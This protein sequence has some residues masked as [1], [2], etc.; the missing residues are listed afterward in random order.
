MYL[1]RY[2]SYMILQYGYISLF[3]LFEE[4]Y[5]KGPEIFI[6]KTYI[7]VQQYHKKQNLYL[8]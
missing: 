7:N 8:F 4:Q 3:K 2:K 1:T 5:M 6:N